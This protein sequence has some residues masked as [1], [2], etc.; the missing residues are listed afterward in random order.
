MHDEVHALAREQ[1]RTNELLTELI[2]QHQLAWERQR[3]LSEHAVRNGASL[4]TIALSVA[5]MGFVVGLLAVFV[6][7][8]AS[9]MKLVGT[10]T[11][12]VAIVLFLCLAA[13]H[14]LAAS[15]S[16]VEDD[17]AESADDSDPR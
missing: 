12:G 8:P 15:R 14:F 5:M 2:E 9:P 7:L 10:V 11:A 4:S 1:Q 16:R 13:R 6:T 3:R 17:E